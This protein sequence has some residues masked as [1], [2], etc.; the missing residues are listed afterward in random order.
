[1]GAGHKTALM[2]AAITQLLGIGALIAALVVVSGCGESSNDNG[3]SDWQTPTLASG[4]ENI[5]TGSAPVGYYEDADDRVFLRGVLRSS[6]AS[7]SD[8]TIFTLAEG[9]RP[10]YTHRFPVLFSIFE[11]DQIIF[12]TVQVT[13]NGVV[14]VSGENIETFSLDTISFRTR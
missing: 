10:V 4:F 8:E 7:P 13:P 1:M 14:S 6:S 11:G 3:N 9:F 5:E 12:A 2:K